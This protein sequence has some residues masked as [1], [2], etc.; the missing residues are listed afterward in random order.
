MKLLNIVKNV[1]TGFMQSIGTDWWIE[2]TTAEPHYTYYFGPFKD[3]EEAKAARLGYIE[4]LEKEGAK[5][6]TDTI[7]RCKPAEVTIPKD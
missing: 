7:K 4:D 3:A 1:A 5:G 6:I 2:V